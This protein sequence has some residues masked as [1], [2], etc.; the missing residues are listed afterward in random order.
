MPQANLLEKRKKEGG[1]LN[2]V[3]RDKIIVL[4]GDTA[5]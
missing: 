1:I 4:K 2:L 5:C 3:L